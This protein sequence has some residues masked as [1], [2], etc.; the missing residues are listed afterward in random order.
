MRLFSV[1][2]ILIAAVF[3]SCDK[4]EVYSPDGLII[5]GSGSF[6]FRDYS[7]LAN[8]PLQVYYHV[9]EGLAS[10]RPVLLVFHGGGR[11]GAF[12][13]DA[14]I[15]KADK[16]R[17]ALLVPEFSRD[18]YPGGD[19]YNLANIFEDGDRPTPETLNPRKE[20]SFSLI[21]SLFNNFKNRSGLTT[22]RYDVFGHSAGGQVAHRF[23][24]FWPEAS[25]NRIVAAAAGWYT[26]PDPLV[27]F[28]YG[29][30]KSPAE[31]DDLS[32]FFSRPL[33]VV[34]GSKDNDP[35]ASSLRRNAQVDRQG[36]DR[37]E[38]AEYFFRESAQQAKKVG[39][40]YA[41][42]FKTLQGVG[43]DFTANAQYA[44]DLLY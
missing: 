14:L 38:R 16:K 34:V 30:G 23:L 36:D 8:D 15:E 26:M 2:F 10:N 21:D 29:L 6:R 27:D 7:G 22:A 3:W 40:V 32:T 41:W 4:N 13:R 11:D 18:Q 19:A 44:A 31:Q 37:L 24:Y 25:C 9:P 35:N 17:F 1:L 20:W 43:H 28:P 33:I 5:K 12:S 42:Q 39:S